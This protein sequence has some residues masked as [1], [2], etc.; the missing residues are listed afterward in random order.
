[1]ARRKW[2]TQKQIT[3]LGI[4]MKIGKQNGEYRFFRNGKPL[5]VSISTRKH[6][7]G[8]DITYP[9]VAFSAAGKPTTI[10]VHVVVWL[11]YNN[12]IYD[13]MDIDH[14]D[15]NK[16]NYNIEN[17]QELTR[18][19]NINKRGTGRNQYSAG[20]TEEEA[21]KMRA[22]KE[23]VKQLRADEINARRENAA[24]IRELKN[25][26]KETRNQIRLDIAKLKLENETCTDDLMF[27]L[28]ST[29]I[30]MYERHART[31]RRYYQEEIK[32]L[33]K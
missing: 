15:N 20:M 2:K 3:D 25:I 7:Y 27:K 19:E 30:K 32:H 21:Q 29:M 4:S 22:D 10:L 26:Y 12:E 6:K 33:M 18:K 5:K 16:L 13:G 31:N 17:L 23:A 24:K 14:I 8:K 9:V 1:M 28:N 11:L